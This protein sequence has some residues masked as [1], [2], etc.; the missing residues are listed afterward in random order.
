[1]EEISKI[2]PLYQPP[3]R[4]L[5]FKESRPRFRHR[6][7][8]WRI[9]SG[10]RLKA[11]TLEELLRPKIAGLRCVFN[12]FQYLIYQFK[13]MFICLRRVHNL[14]KIIIVKGNGLRASV[15]SQGGLLD[16]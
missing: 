12:H 5:M 13:S 16:F 6:I 2:I 9:L 4:G 15:A 7:E 14:A 10:V 3:I 11:L 1:M 8:C